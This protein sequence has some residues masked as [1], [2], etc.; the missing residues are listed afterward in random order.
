MEANGKGIINVLF[1]TRRVDQG[2]PLAGFAWAW[3]R[4]LNKQLAMAGGQLTVV[5]LEPSSA[6]GLMGNI[7]VHS[8]RRGKK[9]RFKDFIAFS[10]LLKSLVSQNDIIFIHQHPVYALIAAPFAKIYRKKI[11]LW[12]VHKKVDYKLRIAAGVCSG[13][14]TASKESFRLRT[15]TPV[16]VVGHGIDTD[17]FTPAEGTSQ[18]STTVVLSVGRL[19][20]IKGYDILIEAVRYLVQQQN[21]VTVRIVGGPGLEGQKEYAAGLEQ[22]VKDKGLQGIVRLVGPVA[23]RDIVNEYRN[24]DVCVN[25]SDTG[26]LDKAVLEAMACGMPVITSNEAYQSIVTPIEPSLYVFRTPDAVA[27]AIKRV[28]AMPPEA[29]RQLGGRLRALVVR[30]HDLKELVKKI[31]SIV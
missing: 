26:S 15:H 17:F 22:M 1:I 7:A 10:I 3:V 20:P 9:N 14:F 29:R 28:I 21:N 5:T 6:E 24:A 12:Y 19:S 4:E 16:H 31:I 25:L 27:T 13:I 2:H 23:H 11:Y 30:D 8:V 18:N